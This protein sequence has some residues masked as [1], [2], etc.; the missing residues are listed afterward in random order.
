MSFSMEHFL[1]SHQ[2]KSLFKSVLHPLQLLFSEHKQHASPHLAI[3]NSF[4]YFYYILNKWIKESSSIRESYY[5]GD[6]TNN[7]A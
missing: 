7:C 4:S 5:D 1:F 6:N 3:P 2:E